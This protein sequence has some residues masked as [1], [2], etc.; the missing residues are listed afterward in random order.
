VIEQLEPRQLLSASSLDTT[1]ASSGKLD[2]VGTVATV[3]TVAPQGSK[4]L[5]GGAANITTFGV[6]R[7]NSNGTLDTSF[8]TS[9]VAKF[10]FGPSHNAPP[11]VTFTADVIAIGFQSDGKIIAFGSTT[12]GEFGVVRFTANGALDTTFGTNGAAIVD[13]RPSPDSTV[14]SN[15]GAMVIA[16]DDSIYLAGSIFYFNGNLVVAHLTSGRTL[17]TNYDGDGKSMTPI[18]TDNQITRVTVNTAIL[19]GDGKLLVASS[20]ESYTDS[21]IDEGMVNRLTTAGALDTT[22]AGSGTVQSSAFGVSPKALEIQAS[23]HILVVGDNGQGSILFSRLDSRGIFENTYHPN[24][25]SFGVAYVSMGSGGVLNAVQFLPDGRILYAGKATGQ[26]GTDFLIGRLNSDITTDITF[27]KN[28]AVQTDLGR[29]DDEAFALAVQPDGKYLAAGL[30]LSGAGA[31]VRYAGTDAAGIW[32][33][34]FDDSPDRF[35]PGRANQTVYLDTNNN[36]TLDTGEPT[37]LSNSVCV[38]SFEGLAAGTYM[39]RLVTPTNFIQDFPADGAGQLV[40]LAAGEQTTGINFGQS[41]GF[42]VG[43]LS[44]SISGSVF[45]DSDQDG[46]H[47]LSESGISGRTVFLDLNNNGEPDYNE[48]STATDS[49]GNYMFTQLPAGTYIVR[50]VLPAGWHQTL[51]AQTTSVLLGDHQNIIGVEFG[52]VQLYSIAGIVFDD[53]NGNGIEDGSEQQLAGRTVYLDT[54]DNSVLDS[55]EPSVVTT[56]TGLYD[57]DFKVQAGNYILREVVPPGS[58]ETTRGMFEGV[59]GSTFSVDNV[60]RVPADLVVPAKQGFFFATKAVVGGSISGTIYNDANAN[61]RRDSGEAGVAGITV[62]DD[63]NNNVKLDAGELT[64]VTDANGAYTLAG[65]SSGSYK[66]RQTLQSGWTQTTP[67][68]NYG[69]TITLAANQQLAGKDFGTKQ[70]GVIPPPTGGSIAGV[71]YNDA[72]GNAKRDAGELGVAAMTVYN[73]AN[74]NSTLDAGEKTTVTDANG[75]YLLSG[76]AAGSYKIREILQSGWSQT[77]PAKN[78]GWT[79]TLSANENG[80]TPPPPPTGGSIAGVVFNDLDGDRVKDSNEVGVGNITIY[81]D[82]NNNSKLDAGELTTTTDSGGAYSLANLSAGSYK[83]REILQS[84][85]SQT[86]PTNNYGWT[87]TLATNQQ[88][89]GR[90]FGT[91]QSGVTPPAMGSISGISF[92]DNNTNGAFDAGDV[93]TS[94]KTVFLDTNNNG[95]LDSG[96]K[97]IVSDANGNWSFTGLSAGTYD[98]RRVFPSGYTYSTTLIDL[99]LNAGDNDSGLLIG[100][101]QIA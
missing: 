16:P 18:W 25:Q 12:G 41:S 101:K 100:S 78:Y 35:I 22:F 64:T 95:K 44:G 27:N 79:I 89:T 88:L 57:F 19:Q 93:K 59:N 42:P 74:N 31:V 54:N 39:V 70:S 24:P 51:P 29:T 72:N 65:L 1:F 80:V 15:P 4:I 40:Q 20:T 75:T 23:N 8:G 83:I 47:D 84:G 17:D 52:S 53:A 86:T 97:S 30:G 21:V 32:G 71:V 9:G 46:V 85:W 11:G 68:N 81:N 56:G 87:I 96:E 26:T 77:T 62:Y 99:T 3:R 58:V 63:P 34:V 55:G 36:G 48:R 98:V 49:A 90:N 50:E 82:A 91:K 92:N 28:L 38:Y 13:F 37:T 67:A 61:G 43:S 7:Y 6:A 76:L 14:S 10:G 73:D 69:W 94:G 5:L 33:S 2:T 60:V 66:I 45:Y